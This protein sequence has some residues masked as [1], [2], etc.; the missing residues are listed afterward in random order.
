M[1]NYNKILES[2]YINPSN[3]SAFLSSDK[4]M[5]SLFDNK[6]MSFNSGNVF[7]TDDFTM[8]S[9]YA[10]I[11]SNNGIIISLDLDGYAMK[12]LY[13]RG[14]QFI[15]DKAIPVDRIKEVYSLN[16]ENNKIE[17]KKLEHIT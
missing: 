11:R 4:S 16:I 15:F 13:N 9:H 2:G 10:S 14:R 8:A 1:E 12:F 6:I 17:V 3:Y 5:Q 7:L